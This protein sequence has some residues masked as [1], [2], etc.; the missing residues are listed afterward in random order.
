M[1]RAKLYRRGS[2]HFPCGVVLVLP[3]PPARLLACTATKR[4]QGSQAPRSITDQSVVGSPTPTLTAF[5]LPPEIRRGMG[6]L[7]DAGG[8]ADLLADGR[9]VLGLCL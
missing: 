5:R 7:R 1:I 6:I 3:A 2:A 4:S 9:D 8:R